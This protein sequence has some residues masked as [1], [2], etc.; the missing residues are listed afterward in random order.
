MVQFSH[1]GFC[2]KFS[3]RD[4]LKSDSRNPKLAAVMSAIV[5][6][7]GQVYNKKYWKVPIIYVGFGALGY[8]FNQYDKDYMLYR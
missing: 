7:S 8:M 1:Q 5:P 3:L 2:Q 4:S 6:G